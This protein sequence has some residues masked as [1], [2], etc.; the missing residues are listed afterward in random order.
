MKNNIPIYIQIVDEVKRQI[1]SKELKPGDKINSVR[2]LAARFGVNPN[3]IQKAL[4]ELDLER[5]IEPKKGVGN[6]VINDE[7]LINRLREE[8]AK[9]IIQEFFFKIQGLGYE[10]EEIEKKINEYFNKKGIDND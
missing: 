1:I 4:N 9:E 7:K 3:T 2:E 6:F 5:I 8:K 10:D